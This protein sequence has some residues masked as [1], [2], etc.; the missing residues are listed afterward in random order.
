MKKIYL[1]ITIIS[2]M[3]FSGCA[4]KEV[5]VEPKISDDSHIVIDKALDSWLKLEKLNYFQKS[6][7]FWVVQARFKNTTYMNRN[8]AYKIDWIDKN[9]FIVKTILSKWKK[10][11]VEEN[12]DF[13][14]NGV[15]PSNQIKDFVIRVQD[16]SRDDEQRKDS[17][18][19]EYQN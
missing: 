15:S 14:I 12:R 18:H 16:T 1:I 7:G 5:K 9:G 2:V 17:S 13:T 8:V 19:Y 10:A 4:Q 11:T 6:D 3:L